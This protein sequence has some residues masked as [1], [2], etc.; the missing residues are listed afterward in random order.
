MQ[1]TT[2]AIACIV[3]AI[4]VAIVTPNIIATTITIIIDYTRV[5]AMV[6]AEVAAYCE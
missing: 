6:I 5:I 3:V 2:G 4:V 1:T